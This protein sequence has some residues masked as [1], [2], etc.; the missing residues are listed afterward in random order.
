MPLN[1]SVPL[2]WSWAFR[3]VNVFAPETF[4]GFVDPK[5]IVFTGWFNIERSTVDSGD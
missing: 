4:E 3:K 5:K 2:S 1:T